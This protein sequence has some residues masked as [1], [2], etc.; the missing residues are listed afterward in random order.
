MA[1]GCPIQDTKDML[2][3]LRITNEK[4]LMEAVPTLFVSFGALG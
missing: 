2:M 3:C 4:T 1:V